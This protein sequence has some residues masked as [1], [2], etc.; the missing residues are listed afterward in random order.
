MSNP[1][2]ELIIAATMIGMIIC[3]VPLERFFKKIYFSPSCPILKQA[4]FPVGTQERR[5]KAHMMGERTFRMLNYV[6]C[7]TALFLILKQEDNGSFLDVRLLGSSAHP[8]YYQ[9][10]PCQI[11]PRHLDNFYI[12][13]LSYHFYELLHTLLLDRHRDDFP[14]YVLHHLMTWALILFSYCS[15]YIPIGA[16]I[17][18]VHDVSD[19]PVTLLKLVVDNT[20]KAVEIGMFLV[21]LV[22][23]T[24]LR[25][26]MF[27]FH[28]VGRMVEECYMVS[29]AGR[30]PGMN[31]QVLN[32]MLAFLLALMGLHI[33]WTYL[34][35]KGIFKRLNK[36]GQQDIIFKNSATKID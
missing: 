21:M 12:F 13:K 24:Y 31:Y 22:S 5:A 17:M 14:E 23:W 8:L 25:L 33:F 7:S 32:M 36:S 34:M 29:E 2:R 9:N 3:Q 4:K 1:N 35:F 10:Y 15:N 18:L 11:L 19:L 28:I 16:V 6:G 30:I 20:P 26:W 27:P